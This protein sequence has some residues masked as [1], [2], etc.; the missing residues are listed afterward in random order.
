VAGHRPVP[1]RWSRLERELRERY[2]PLIAGVDEVGRGPLAGPVVAC[3]VV[4]PPDARALRG[5]DDSKLLTPTERVRLAA[6]IRQ[7]ALAVGLGAASVREID[8]LNIYHASV[9]AMRRALARLPLRPDHV[10]VDGRP[11]RS[12]AVEHTAVVG[13]DGCC[14][15]I[16]C[17]SIVAKVTR[18]RLMVALA[19]RHPGYLWERN[20]GY[21]TRAHLDG[22]RSRGLTAHHRRSFTPRAFELELA[23]GDEGLADAPRIVE[24]AELIARLVDDALDATEPLGGG[25][26]LPDGRAGR[27][28]LERTPHPE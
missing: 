21:A 5:V 11:I 25:D 23:L 22:L 26:P 28:G 14:P 4:M 13:G 15:S 9:L 1:R 12:L 27:G 19:R 18:D 8:R 20:A 6:R 24:D 17:A 3:A 16:A 10:L 2:G 7:R